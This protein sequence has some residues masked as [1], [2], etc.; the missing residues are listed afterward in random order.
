MKYFLT[1]GC[2]AKRYQNQ[3]TLVGLNSKPKLK[4]TV[5]Y[6]LCWTMVKSWRITIMADGRSV[7]KN[8]DDPSVYG[9]WWRHQNPIPPAKATDGSYIGAMRG[10]LR[11][12]QGCAWCCDIDFP[13]HSDLWK[14]PGQGHFRVGLSSSNWFCLTMFNHHLLS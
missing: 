8:S 7:G 11:R 4:E 14:W 5:L 12:K 3:G 6:F 13:L 10:F 1:N 2:L 9:H